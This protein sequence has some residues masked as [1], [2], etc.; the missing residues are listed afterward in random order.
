[1]TSDRIIRP[2]SSN[3]GHEDD[4]LENEDLYEAVI[5]NTSLEDSWFQEMMRQVGAASIFT[6]EDII[7][8]VWLTL[9]RQKPGMVS[10][11]EEF[12]EKLAGDIKRSQVDFQSLEAAFRSKSIRHDE[13]VRILYEEMELQIKQEREKILSEKAVKEKHMRGQLGTQ[14]EEKEKQLDDILTRQQELEKQMSALN[15]VKTITK[16]ENERLEKEKEQLESLLSQSQE[17]L[18]ASRMYIQQIELQQQEVTKERA[19]SCDDILKLGSDKNFLVSFHQ[20]LQDEKLRLM[21]SRRA[22]MSFSES[23]AAQKDSLQ[24]QLGILRDINKRL[25]DDKDEAEAI[26][27]RMNQS[28]AVDRSNSTSA[29]KKNFISKIQHYTTAFPTDSMWLLST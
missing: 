18:E 10:A 24:I 14:L 28:R 11:F 9:H 16:Q 4:S 21:K 7:K 3:A 1:M 17:T 25:R 23:V 8:A 22:V 6:D 2:G 12:I 13:E 15:K 19:R 27:A 29:L 5:M 26:Q 20:D